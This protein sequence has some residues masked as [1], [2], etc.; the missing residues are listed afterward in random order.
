VGLKTTKIKWIMKLGRDYCHSALDAESKLDTIYEIFIRFW[1]TIYKSKPPA[2]H[3]CYIRGA[4]EL[5]RYAE[6]I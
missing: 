1:R 4:S 5:Q 3:E 2:E 6:N